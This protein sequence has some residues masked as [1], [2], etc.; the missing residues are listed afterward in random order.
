MTNSM[1]TS[2]LVTRRLRSQWHQHRPKKA[3]K[4][5]YFFLETSARLIHV[6]HKENKL[7]KKCSFLCFL[8]L[9]LFFEKKRN[10]VVIFHLRFL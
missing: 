5:N 4:L 1:L 8:H 6:K 10:L 2:I 7:G 3:L 9:L